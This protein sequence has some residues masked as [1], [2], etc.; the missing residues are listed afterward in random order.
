MLIVAPV[1]TSAVPSTEAVEAGQ[2]PPPVV[3]SRT[4]VVPAVPASAT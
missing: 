4:S 1:P 3:V 2:V